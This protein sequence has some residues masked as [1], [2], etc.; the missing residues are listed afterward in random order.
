MRRLIPL[1]L[2]VAG[3]IVALGAQQQPPP[4]AQAPAAQPPAAQPQ[5]ATQPVQ[6]PVAGQR[7]PPVFRGGTNQVRVDVTVLNRK[8]E[9]LTDLTKDDFEVREDGE[10]QTIDNLKLV[11][12]NG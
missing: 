8:G 7:Q 4:A 10:L 5:A 3:A 6:P 12:A 11:E 1:C 9:P 2:V